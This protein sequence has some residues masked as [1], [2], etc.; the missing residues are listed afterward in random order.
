[1]QGMRSPKSYVTAVSM[2]GIFGTLGIHHFYLGRW[3]HGVFDLSLALT[4]F[5][6]LFLYWPLAP[7]IFFIDI[8]HTVYFMYKL[9][10]G[11]Y[12]DGLGRV[13]LIDDGKCDKA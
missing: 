9:I 10:V 1:M 11:E 4:A 5:V 2:A 12:T 3:M 6:F 13:V 8:V 7:V